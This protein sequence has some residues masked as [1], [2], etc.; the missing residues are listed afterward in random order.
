MT[1]GIRVL[2]ASWLTVGVI[3]AAV[4]L[5]GFVDAPV[6]KHGRFWSVPLLPTITLAASWGAAALGVGLW[7]ESP[8]V[9]LWGRVMS[10]PLF[11]LSIWLTISGSLLFALGGTGLET[12]LQ[13]L[14]GVV[15]LVVT[16]LNYRL[17]RRAES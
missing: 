3:L 15:G 7:K 2:S 10:V 4:A 14:G 6:Q 12:S 5:M 9:A 8:S 16:V 13:F 17:A 11:A 1:L